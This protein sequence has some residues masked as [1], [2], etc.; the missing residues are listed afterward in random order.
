MRKQLIKSDK[1]DCVITLGSNLFYGAG[2]PACLLI[3]REQKPAHKVGK[4]LMID[5]SGI[6]TP[7][8]AQNE[9]S[10]ENIDTI[11]KLYSDYQNIDE[12]AKIVTI[13]DIESKAYTLSVSRYIERRAAEVRPYIEVKQEFLSAY[14]AVK[15]AESRFSQLLASEGYI[16][17]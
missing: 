17:E 9:L 8:R 6:Y 12:I 13:R 10:D 15:E 1:L 2:I 14:Q 4:V 7:K 11:F 3:F 5:A 16:N